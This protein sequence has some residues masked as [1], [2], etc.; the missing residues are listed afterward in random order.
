MGQSG[1]GGGGG[2]KS[3]TGGGRQERCGGGVGGLNQLAEGR[4]LCHIQ[5]EV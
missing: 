5:E 4:K 1:G 3:E 2:R